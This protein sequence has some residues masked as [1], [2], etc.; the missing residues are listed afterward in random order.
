[1]KALKSDDAV[2]FNVVVIFF[3]ILAY[4]HTLAPTPFVSIN[5]IDP[6][7]LVIISMRST[8]RQ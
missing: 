8:G 3:V 6:F 1:M 4:S 7:S 2:A 5:S